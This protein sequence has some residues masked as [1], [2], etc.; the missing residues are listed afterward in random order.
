MSLEVTIMHQDTCENLV[1][2]FP[3]FSFL[4]KSRIPYAERFLWKRQ[5]TLT[6]SVDCIFLGKTGYGKST[7]LN[8][9]IG[10][11][12][13]E[14]SAISACTREVHCADFSINKKDN[15][16]FSLGDLPGVGENIKKDK[17][18]ILWYTAYLEACAAA[19][20]IL[21]ADQRDFSVDMDV[22]ENVVRKS[23]IPVL[24]GLNYCDKIEPLNRVL[25]F[26]P[27]EKQKKN[28]SEKITSVQEIFKMPKQDII[29]FSAGA[30]WNMNALAAGIARK[31]R[32]AFRTNL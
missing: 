6:R 11:S 25:P 16:W 1:R 2:R 23:G 19:V 7:A 20:Y 5:E 22:F 12:V 13:F 3:V 28:L 10:S 9:L 24:I 32:A 30:G 27:S 26:E 17:K 8:A 21:R 29:P 14:T 15:T 4:R 31:V 18:Y